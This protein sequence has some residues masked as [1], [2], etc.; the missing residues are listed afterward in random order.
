MEN[1]ITKINYHTLPNGQKYYTTTT[2]GN[3]S[4]IDISTFSGEVELLK[5][6]RKVF[7]GTLKNGEF[8]G[9]GTIYFRNGDEF[10]VFFKENRLYGEGL[11]FTHRKAYIKNFNYSEFCNQPIT[12]LNIHGKNVRKIHN[13]LINNK[14]HR[15]KIKTEDIFPININPQNTVNDSYYALLSENNNTIETTENYQNI[16][17]AVKQINIKGSMRSDI[18]ID[19]EQLRKLLEATEEINTNILNVQNRNLE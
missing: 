6:G 18:E 12:H 4:I 11:F 7:D 3:T 8:S 10:S 19:K 17:D 2:N 1:N 13:Y 5:N 14:K 15:I 9:H 16:I